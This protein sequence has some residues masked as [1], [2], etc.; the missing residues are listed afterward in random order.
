MC[1]TVR[2]KLLKN[3]GDRVTADRAYKEKKKKLKKLIREKWDELCNKLDEDIWGDGYRIV[4][5]SLTGPSLPFSLT[6]EFKEEVL[7]T[8][9]PSR[10]DMW[11]RAQVES[12]VPFSLAELQEGELRLKTGTAPGPDKVPPEV[13]KELIACAPDF[14]LRILNSL[15]VSQRFTDRWKCAKVVL[16]WKHPKLAH[17][18]RSYRP[19]S[20]LDSIA[21]LYEALICNRL[22]QEIRDRGDFLDNQNG[23][24]KGRSTLNAMETILKEIK[25]CID[26]YCLM[27]TM[28]IRNASPTQR[29]GAK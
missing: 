20:L 10:S 26:K 13:V 19:I 6:A 9:F 8:L 16:L 12:P 17:D 27:I 24:R 3:K 29:H 28:H 15:M 14:V 2:R 11:E 4:K 21:K 18:T 7:S 22:V 5:K 23:F 1:T 25:S